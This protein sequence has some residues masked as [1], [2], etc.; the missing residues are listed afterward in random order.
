MRVA[1]LSDSGMRPAGH[2]QRSSAAPEPTGRQGRTSTA[3]R[4][5]THAPAARA[6]PAQPGGPQ[7]THRPPTAAAPRSAG[8]PRTPPAWLRPLPCRTAPT[9]GLRPPAP[10]GCRRPA[11]ARSAG[12]WCCAATSARSAAPGPRARCRAGTAGLAAGWPS[13]RP[14]LQRRRHQQQ[15]CRLRPWPVSSGR[16]TTGTQARRKQS[17]GPAL[18]SSPRPHLS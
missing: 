13:R 11:A 15:G 14:G 6:G 2:P 18:A 4:P 9:A 8:P 5:S 7:H 17:A 1:A 10:G 3:R 16:P 12:L